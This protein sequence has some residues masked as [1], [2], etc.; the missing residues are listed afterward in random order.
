METRRKNRV[1]S[2]T[3]KTDVL[4]TQERPITIVRATPPEDSAWAG[5]EL[6]AARK[7]WK[8]RRQ[9]ATRP[10]KRTTSGL[11]TIRELCVF[12][13]IEMPLASPHADYSS[14]STAFRNALTDVLA[15]SDA[16]GS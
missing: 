7:Q 5:S 2:S 16:A 4:R 15:A 10:M 11:P 14:L 1:K 13:R 8:N 6:E 9:W 12:A 3:H